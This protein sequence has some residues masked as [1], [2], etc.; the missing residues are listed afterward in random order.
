M[1]PR[2]LL[3]RS[4][5]ELAVMDTEELVRTLACRATKVYQVTV[6]AAERESWRKS[7]ETVTTVLLH[8]G[9]DEVMVLLEMSTLSSDARI[10]MLLVGTHPATGSLSAVVVENKQWSHFEV[11]PRTRRIVHRG[12]H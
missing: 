10:D 9:L 6:R 4:A 3:A 12:G 8:A 1:K 11:I 5:T 2:Y 7:I